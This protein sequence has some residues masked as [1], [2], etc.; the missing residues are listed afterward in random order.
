MRAHT[1]I[2]RRHF[3]FRA[4]LRNSGNRPFDICITGKQAV[5]YAAA[6]YFDWAGPPA[7]PIGGQRRG[8]QL[9]KYEPADWYHFQLCKRLSITLS[10]TSKFV[11]IILICRILFPGEGIPEYLRNFFLLHPFTC[12]SRVGKLP[13][14][15]IFLAVLS[16]VV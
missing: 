11:P 15:Y 3:F 13:F 9:L 10:E 4:S 8:A 5:A 14:D 6:A 2:F 7:R 12:D 16:S 1:C